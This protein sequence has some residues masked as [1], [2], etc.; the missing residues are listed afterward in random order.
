MAQNKNNIPHQEDLTDTDR[1][2]LR[3]Y[4]DAKEPIPWDKSDDAVMAFSASI[5]EQAP[6]GEQEPEEGVEEPTVVPFRRPRAAAPMAVFRSPVAGLAIA[7]SLMIGVVVGQTVL[8]QFNQDQSR[9]FAQVIADNERLAAQVERF[10]DLENADEYFQV[11]EE[12]ATLQAELED[13]KALDTAPGADQIGMPM[14]PAMDLPALSGLFD[15]FDCSALTARTGPGATVV[16]D[17]YVG[18]E[19]DLARL[20]DALGE[21]GAIVNQVQVAPA[22]FC[23]A[24]ETLQLQTVTYGGP[25]VRPY[26]HGPVFDQ[27]ESLVLAATASGQVDGYLYVDLFSADGQVRHLQG[28]AAAPGQDIVLDAAASDAP[29]GQMLAIAVSTPTPLFDAARPE[30]EPA[31]AYLSALSEALAA[32]DGATSGHSFVTVAPAD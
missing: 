20:G 6:D 5:H 31:A 15:S 4:E 22:P 21:G 9:D 27:G 23:T 18:T 29:I 1:A 12:N 7:A 14:T 10:G 25:S 32:Q 2:V 13:L 30:T 26:N 3:L 24:L 8:P 16:V 11:L 19:A 28:A 17:G